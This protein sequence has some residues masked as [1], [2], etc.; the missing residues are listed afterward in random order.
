[1]AGVAL[2]NPRADIELENCNS[3]FEGVSIKICSLGCERKTFLLKLTLGFR[4]RVFSRKEV[5]GA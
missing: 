5:K 1:M 2:A 3:P 4:M